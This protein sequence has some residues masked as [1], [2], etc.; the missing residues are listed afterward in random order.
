MLMAFWR[1]PMH[2]S[3]TR[4]V[5]VSSAVLLQLLI[6]A[7]MHVR[8]SRSDFP[9]FFNFIVFG[10]IIQVFMAAAV[11]LPASSYFYS[12]WTV[13]ALGALLGFG[14]LYESVAQIMKP[15]S[16]LVD[17]AKMLLLW[18]GAFLLIVSFLAALATS[19]NTTNKVCAAIYLAQRC[20]L[21]M[22][23]G[24]LFLL[25]LF[26]KR[27][28]A[29]WLSRGMC[30]TVGLGISAAVDLSMVLLADR[31]PAWQGVLNNMSDVVSTGVLLYWAYGMNSFGRVK[32]T[33][34]NAPNRLILQRWNDALIGYG[35]G[36]AT[37]AANTDSFIPGVEQ[38]VERV[39]ARKAV[40]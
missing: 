27:L 16:A 24:L 36:G 7:I 31:L 5:F 8:K 9:I 1:Y 38:A 25:L 15:Y 19:G 33:V 20:I 32:A 35:Y 22:Q 13:T 23:C 6:L 30:V 21:F 10:V 17:L 4:W 28:G 37:A 40:H 29:S 3:V 34:N 12:F 26:E 14:V 39:L 2:M 18:G 11:S